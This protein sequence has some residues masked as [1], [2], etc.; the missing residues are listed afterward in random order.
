MFARSSREFASRLV[1]R[2]VPSRHRKPIRQIGPDNASQAG[3][4][5][6]QGLL[7]GEGAGVLV[8]ESEEHARNRGAAIL[9]RVLGYGLSCDAHHI[10]G[11]HPDGEG[12]AAC[13]RNALSNARA[14]PDDVGYICCHGTGTHQNDRIEAKAIHRVFGERA[15]ALPVSS[16]KALT[17]HMMG[18]ASAVEAIACV[19]ALRDGVLP[20]TWNHRGLDPECD[21][22]VLPNQPRESRVRLVLNN[23]YAFGG[24]NACVAFGAP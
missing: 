1:A 13:M 22:D 2:S 9:A 4:N 17:G 23:S 3:S 19:L 6:K 24:N 15:R 5:A 12:A 20:P 18:A 21:L 14:D 8:L 7:L 16:I 10:T 11:P